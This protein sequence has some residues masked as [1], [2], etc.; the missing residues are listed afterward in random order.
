MSLWN[1]LAEKHNY[2]Q[3]CQKKWIV[4]T[5]NTG[6]HDN[7][8]RLANSINGWTEH[9]SKEEVDFVIFCDDKISLW[10]NPHPQWKIINI[11]LVESQYRE[12]DKY[13]TSRKYKL[14]IDEIFYDYENSLY[15]DSNCVISPK[16]WN[17]MKRFEDNNYTNSKH[18]GSISNL[19]LDMMALSHRKHPHYAD[20][21]DHAGVHLATTNEKDNIIRQ[22]DHYNSLSNSE[23]IKKMP[24]ITGRILIRRHTYA[25]KSLCNFWY[26]EAQKWT[27][28][29]QVSWQYAYYS[30]GYNKIS[31]DLIKEDKFL[32]SGDLQPQKH[33][34]K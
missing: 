1:Q 5:V 3:Q 30:R 17:M 19:K 21:A 32:H 8:D 24:F 2:T 9:F 27:H 23:T 13:L 29:D 6:R 28:R 14:S 4:Y 22:R 12:E 26:E 34:N 25:I 7:P 11:P 10:K 15:I 16:V 31:L 18:V 20:E 33:L